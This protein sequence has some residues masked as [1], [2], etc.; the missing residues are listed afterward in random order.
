MATNE[1]TFDQVMKTLKAKDYKPVY[2]L[3]GEEDYYI[4][5]ITSYL[6]ENLLTEE[7][8]GFNQTVLYGSDVDAGQIIMAARRY[9]MM[10]DKQLILV[11]EAQAVRD[12]DNLS[13]YL[14]NPMPSTVLVL[15]YKHGTFDRRKKLIGAV[16]KLGILF[17]SKK[18]KDNSLVTFITTFLRQRSVE[19]ENAS[20]Q[21]LADFV[22]SALNRLT[23]ELT[24]LII[25]LPQGTKRITPEQIEKNIG[26]SKEYNS[27]EL[28][29]ALI[30]RDV[31]K[32]YQIS[33]HFSKNQKQNPIQMT[34]A[35]LFGFFSNLM[36]AYYAP[37]RTPDGVAAQLGLRGAWAAD[38]YIVAMR[39]YSGMKCMQIISE[40]RT[41]DARSKGFPSGGTPS[42][43]GEILRDLIYFIL[44]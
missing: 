28:R 17:E 14:Q 8:K 27:F 7:E 9:P 37:Q 23:G 40:I 3:M 34:L 24:K 4:D 19:I 41:S 22:G 43:D 5:R 35:T 10:S 29:R 15:C 16:Q 25:T 13:I 11:K 44:H 32:S 33:D 38:D 2:L 30:Y 21:L 18:I 26:I 31:M 1:M 6:E 36:L 20:A 42:T 12:L 39:N